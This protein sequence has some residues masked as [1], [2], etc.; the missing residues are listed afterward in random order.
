MT[1][2]NHCVRFSAFSLLLYLNDDFEGGTTTFLSTDGNEGK[3]SRKGNTR[4]R[5]AKGAQETIMADGRLSLP[6]A[7]ALEPRDS[8]GLFE[9]RQ[10][11]A[12]D[13][14]EV[15]N[16]NC[17]LA[18]FHWFV[19]FMAEVFAGLVSGRARGTNHG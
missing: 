3:R 19:S 15:L 16:V 1:S 8:A 18:F 4:V 17:F 13:H 7:E 12:S 10:E 11:L 9:Q 2:N 6:S 14:L 5:L